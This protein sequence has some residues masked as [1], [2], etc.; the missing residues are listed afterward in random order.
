MAFNLCVGIWNDTN[1]THTYKCVFCDFDY[2]LPTLHLTGRNSSRYKVKSQNKESKIKQFFFLVWK[3]GSSVSI[4]PVLK[5]RNYFVFFM[6]L[7]LSCYATHG[8][9]KGKSVREFWNMKQVFR[10]STATVFVILK[11]LSNEI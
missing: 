9:Y 6:L 2:N 5:I 1:G 8:K 11:L 7:S 3:V 4:F 10:N